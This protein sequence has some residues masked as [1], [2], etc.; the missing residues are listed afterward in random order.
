MN[1]VLDHDIPYYRHFEEMTRIPHGSYNEKPYSDYLVRWAK[2]HKLKY[3]QDDMG[4]VIMYKPASAGRED[5]APVLLQGH[6]DMVCDKTPESTHDFKKDPLQLY[7]EDGWL[8]AHNTTL[9][10]DD[11]VGCAYMLSILENDNLAHPPLECVFT[12]Q[13][14]VGCNGAANLKA[15]YFSAKRMLGLDDDGGGTSY[16]TTA[17]S[18]LTKLNRAVHWEAGTRQAYKLSV[19]GLL[20]GHSGVDIEKELGSSIKIAASVLFGLL[21]KGEL[22]LADIN[23]GSAS[24]VI[25]C[26]G[27]V[28]FASSLDGSE[29]RAVV[30]KYL[31]IFREQ[32]RWSDP[33]L[34]FELSECEVDKVMSE[35]DTRDIVCFTRFVKD[36]FFH[37]SMRFDGLTTVSSNIGIWKLEG[38]EVYWECNSRSS[39]EAFIDMIEEDHLASCE[40]YHIERQ[41][42]GR[43]SGFDYIEDSPIRKALDTSFFEVTGR[44]IVEIFVHGGI[45]AGHLT[46]II[47]G[48]DVATIGPLM[49][50]VHTVNERLNLESFDV[51][52][53]TL[54]KMLA[55]L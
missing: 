1:N 7:V 14:E 23:M 32:L 2:E 25:P 53:A 51:I 55:L 45:E 39:M 43:V 11:G 18:Q 36:G 52:W 38:D 4:N 29:V 19:G 3:V 24:N 46:K 26:H 5:R 13:E 40:T 9:G 8:K 30:D 54:V 16:V 12:V 28:V 27:S 31:R 42:T 49:E 21:K 15:E 17:G 34:E 22:R 35:A 6:M 48:L 37:K 50:H 41:E 47:P 33:N 10:A 44:H 20:G